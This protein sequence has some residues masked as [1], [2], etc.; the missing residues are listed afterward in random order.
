MR[1]VA[2]PVPG[3][4][5]GAMLAAARGQRV[6]RPHWCGRH[7]ANEARGLCLVTDRCGARLV[8]PWLPGEADIRASD[9]EVC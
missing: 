1:L 6:R 5:A 2:D 4:F 3:S 7:V 8:E 9:W